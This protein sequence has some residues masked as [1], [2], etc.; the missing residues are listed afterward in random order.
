MESA[1][2]YAWYVG[3]R[4]GEITNNPKMSGSIILWGIWLWIVMFPFITPLLYR[5]LPEVVDIV[6]G[7]SLFISPLLFCHFRYTKQ[8]RKTLDRKYRHMKNI[9]SRLARLVVLCIVLAIVAFRLSFFLGLLRFT[10]E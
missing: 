4:F 7:I 6:V 5:Y 2:D 8:R 9:G 10:D 1:L 3:E